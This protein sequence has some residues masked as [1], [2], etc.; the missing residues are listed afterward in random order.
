M[1]DR[2]DVVVIGSGFGGA[3]TAARL[4]QA[5]LS[6]AV[7]ERG[8][9][10]SKT[11]F[12]RTTGQVSRGFWQERE[13]HGFLEY[14]AFKRMDV[15]QGVGVGGGSL[16]YFNVHLRPRS[17]IFDSP[18]WPANVKRT[19][20]DP[21]YDIAEQV[22]GSEPLKAPLGR[23]LPPRT[24]FFLEAAQRAGHSAA[25]VPI[26]VYTGPDRLH[27]LGGNPQTA[28]INCGNCLLGC[29][30]HAKN[31]LDFTYLGLAERRHGAEVFPSHVVDGIAPHGDGFE[32]RFRRL[33]PDQPEQSEPGSVIGRRVVVAAGTLGSNELLLR[34][35]DV[36]RTLPNLSPALGRGFSGNGDM[37][38]ACAVDTAQAIDPGYGPSIT[39]GAS[40]VQDQHRITIED[41][42]FPDP[43]F[44]FLEGILPPPRK[45]FRGLK[46]LG[47]AYVLA[48]LGFSPRQSRVSTEVDNLLA[49]GRT[50]RVL[51]FLGM[52]N[53]ASDGVLALR[54]GEI[55][56]RW[57]H[58]ASRDMFREME[59]LMAQISGASGGRYTRSLL[60]RWPFRKLLTAHPLGGCAVGD[61]GTSSVSNHYGEVW[62]YPGLHVVDGSMVPS[63]LAVNPSLT[64]SA[65]AERAAFWILHGREMR[66]SDPAQPA[67]G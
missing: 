57:S 35:R 13:T 24:R 64:I 40:Y 67:A 10:W 6:V 31:T 62:N 7:L 12:P 46:S 30:V 42:G 22:L 11:D 38:F 60:W 29:H 17:D 4:A 37:L 19:V 65:L 54:D 52:G 14:R 63:A 43:F 8:K 15:I 34:C 45:R 51:P 3:V 1:K 55:D 41:L 21:Y 28:C 61:N 27:P 53:D 5:G 23:A 26:G 50:S 25:L 56:L 9:R 39:A 16:H 49:N 66:A 20:L 44:W 2:Y 58:K 59:R 48:A 47:L 33:D 18:R 32:V 36:D